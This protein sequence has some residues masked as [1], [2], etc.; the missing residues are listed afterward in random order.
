[1]AYRKKHDDFDEILALFAIMA[2]CLVSLF[3]EQIA[4]WVLGAS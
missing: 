1:M 4:D 3:A 2:V